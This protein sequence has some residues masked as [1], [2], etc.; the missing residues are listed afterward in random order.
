MEKLWK[1]S[2]V[3]AA[4]IHNQP[5]LLYGLRKTAGVFAH[6]IYTVF[7]YFC[8]QNYGHITDTLNE[9]FTLSTRPIISSHNR[10]FITFF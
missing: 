5:W 3:T 1:N 4:S 9:F 10:T 6:K 8:T 2:S 7:R